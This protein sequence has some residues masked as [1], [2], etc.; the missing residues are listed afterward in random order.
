ML[1]PIKRIGPI[2]EEKKIKKI[3][4]IGCGDF[5]WMSNLLKDIEFDSYLGLDIVKKLVEMF[6]VNPDRTKITLRG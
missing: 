4:D 6:S 5:N 3:L 1:D 2:A